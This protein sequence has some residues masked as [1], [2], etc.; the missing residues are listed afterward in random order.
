MMKKEGIRRLWEC[1]DNKAEGGGGS[2]D[3]GVMAELPLTVVLQQG[4]RGY[5]IV[6][7]TTPWWVA[8]HAVRLPFCRRDSFCSQGQG[9][10]ST[11][12]SSTTQT[13]LSSRGVH[14]SILSGDVVDRLACDT[15]TS[16]NC[17]VPLDLSCFCLF[18]PFKSLNQSSW[19]PIFHKICLFTEH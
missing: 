13:R 4:G 18:E 2:Q 11:D 10:Q 19:E 6:A 8:L 15:A 7:A 3:A 17:R 14:A 16:M 12:G 9:W 5:L 1:A